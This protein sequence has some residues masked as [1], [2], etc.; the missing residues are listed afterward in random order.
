[1]REEAKE[2]HH[3]HSDFRFDIF[4]A[5]RAPLVSLNVASNFTPALPS[6]AEIPDPPDLKKRRHD[7]NHVLQISTLDVHGSLTV[8]VSSK[9]SQISPRLMKLFLK[10][11]RAQ[12]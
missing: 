12:H 4:D 7:G 11:R 6:A 10:T 9:N 8:T 2:K 5:G 1:L 3:V